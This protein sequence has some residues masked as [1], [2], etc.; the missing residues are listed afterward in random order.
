MQSVELDDDKPL[1]HKPLVVEDKLPRISRVV[2][3]TVDK[4]S[5]VVEVEVVIIHSGRS[6]PDT[7][8]HNL[9]RSL[10]NF[11]EIIFIT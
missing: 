6:R 2:V 1:S 10:A 7:V 3:A 11:L 9:S 5:E 4:V 8:L